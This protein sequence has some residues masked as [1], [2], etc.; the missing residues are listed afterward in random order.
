M[1]IYGVDIEGIEGVLIRFSAVLEA[2]T[3]GRA[4]LGLAQK[5]VKEGYERAIKAIEKIEGNWN[6][7]NS[8]IT[9][10]LS[11]SSTQKKSEGLDLPIAITILTASLLQD[12]SMLEECIAELQQKADKN[13]NNKEK[14]DLRDKILKQI[15]ELIE[16]RERILKYKK[17]ITQNTKK[18][19]FIGTLDI[20]SGDIEPPR[21]GTF[22]MLSSIGKDYTVIVPEQSDIHAALVAKA[23]GFTA[24]RAFNL[25]E[26]WN[27]LIGESQPRKA[28]Y[29]KSKLERKKVISYVPDLHAINGVSKA[30]EAMSI[31]VA[32]GHNILMVGPPGQGKSMLSA[33]ATKLLPK[34]TNNEIFEINK[35]YSAK[36]EL[37]D[38][39]IITSRPYVEVSHATPEA[40][41]FGGG[42]PPTPGE[43]SLAHRGIL[44]FDEINLFKSQIIERLRT[45]LEEHKSIVQRVS[46]RIEYPCSFI[47]IATMNP[48]K[49]GWYNHFQCP[50]CG[51]IF[52]KRGKCDKDQAKL[53]HKCKCNKR[54][55]KSYKDKLSNPM[56]DRM[57]L[58]VLLSSHDRNNKNNFSFSSQTVQRKITTAREIQTERYKHSD[59]I[60]CNADIRDGYQYTQFDSL[61]TKIK[62]YLNNISKKLD[63]TPRQKMRLQLISRTVAD[64]NEAEM[65]RKEDINKALILMGL[66]REYFRKF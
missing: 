61:D 40:P 8:K 39:E 25:N 14:K 15:E 9:M 3:G 35:I 50:K 57:D 31:A 17:I 51:K 52:I 55:I 6:L 45:P 11:P 43:I 27:I 47:M 62:V 36:G 37:H 30:K 59:S 46:G 28:R 48:C 53:F 38:N 23:K 18:Y 66:D 33:A 5:V 4:I 63:I 22:G 10:Q 42:V 49:C 65:V 13:A 32:G 20:A 7:S 34:L 1:E 58:K 41:L 54:E 60:F 56:K 44:L 26:V 12:E 16:Q 29:T 64:F 24:Y 2:N 19:C 21:Y